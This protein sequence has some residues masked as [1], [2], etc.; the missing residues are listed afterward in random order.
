MAA[1]YKSLNKA[2][3]QKEEAPAVRKNKQRV[4][5]LS[6]RGVTYRQRHFLNDLAS[7]MPHGRKDAKFD[8]K[9]KLWELN[10]LAEMYNTNNILF[11]EARKHTDL[12]LWMAR[13]PKSVESREW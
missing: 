9:S 7:L 5:I 3:G 6:S 4:L 2:S 12:Y 11:A 1:V 13:A 10:E 8:S